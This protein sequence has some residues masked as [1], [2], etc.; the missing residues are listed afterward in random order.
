MTAPDGLGKAGTTLWRDV[1]EGGKYDLRP[2]E[3]R[4][5]EAACRQYDLLAMLEA[6]L[7][8]DLA[9]GRYKVR[10]SQGQDVINPLIS[11]VRQHRMA[12]K[13]LLAGLN[14]PDENGEV[15]STRSTHAR[16]AAQ[17]RWGK[18]G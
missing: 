5:L 3:L 15:E 17:S 4:L 9:D 14:L 6:A 16:K 12:F 8:T 10:G 7:A 2:D 13:S 18:T 11:E 1:A